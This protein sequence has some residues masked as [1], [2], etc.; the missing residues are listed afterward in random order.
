MTP[1]NGY[2]ELRTVSRDVYTGAQLADRA[3]IDPKSPIPSKT[4]FP[5]NSLSSFLH[6]TARPLNMLKFNIP[7]FFGLV[8]PYPAHRV[9]QGRFISVISCMMSSFLEFLIWTTS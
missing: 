4:T 8:D 7:A 1:I 6:V 9:V 2:I 5:P 3:V